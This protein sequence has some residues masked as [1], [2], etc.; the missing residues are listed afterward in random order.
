MIQI[1]YFYLFIVGVL[2]IL[3]ISDLVVGVGNDAV[4]FLNG[5]IGSKAAKFKV[6]LWV[7]T[8]G[9]IVGS[10]FS[11]GMM[12]I[13]RNGVFYPEKFVFAEV[14]IIF[15]A[16]MFADVL[17]LDVFN[18]LGLPTSTTVSI[19]F[20]LIGAALAVAVFKKLSSDG[21]LSGVAEYINT[22]N[23]LG[24][25]S[26]ILLSV[27]ISF[28]FGALIQYIARILFTFNIEKNYKRFAAIWGG[29][30]IS[31]ITYFLL[32]KGLKGASFISPETYSLIKHNTLLIM[33]VSL[34]AWTAILQLL[35]VLFKVNSLKIVVLFGTFA[36]AMSFAG[37]DLVNFIGVPLAG[38]ESF[39][40][41]LAN[42]GINPQSMEMGYLNN[43]IKT[44]TFFLLSAGVIMALTLWFSKK[45]RT[46]TRTEVNL[47]RQTEGSERFQSSALSRSIV[48]AFISMGKFLDLIVP[49]R[50]QKW[51]DK[52]FKQEK[53]KSNI[54]DKDKPSFDL[55]RGSVNLVVSSALIALGTS[56]KLP[57]STTYVTF[58]V[59]MGSSFSDQAWGRE[60]AV[61]RVSGVLTVIG[62]WFITAFVAFTLSFI[63]ATALYFGGFIALIIVIAFVFFI[64]YRSHTAHRQSEK[65]QKEVEEKVEISSI[66]KIKAW[67]A[68]IAAYMSASEDFIED[69]IKFLIQEKRGKM[70][71]VIN[72]NKKLNKELKELKS[73]SPYIIKRL[74]DENFDNG[75][76]YVQSIDQVKEISDCYSRLMQNIW[77]YID[78][79]HP[80]I[81]LDQATDL[82]SLS[83]EVG[84][85][86]KECGK[87][88]AKKDFSTLHELEQTCETLEERIDK[89]SV[90]NLKLIKKDEIGTRSSVLV[91]H[92][93]HETK[94]IITLN[95]KVIKCMKKFD[96]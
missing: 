57:L 93:L 54:K 71:K 21:G 4:N 94:N 43:A 55:V 14:M 50:M 47:S 82:L 24:F 83:K 87:A 46:V 41:F 91:T 75:F 59:A 28:T 11:S 90:K 31:I 25:M 66:E 13:A 17:L 2:F 1:E 16:V 48:R 34:I 19:L 64:A 12:E 18:T 8:A 23:I 39:K 51:L 3:A 81:H 56:L 76:M 73:A 88:I 60:S 27:V 63:I 10:V 67:N 86:T 6:I 72:E 30:S 52:R 38:Y 29:L 69:P 32:I 53:V 95:L 35:S 65:K 40:V 89:L 7:A 77:K 92:I 9:V 5:A 42:S 22:A 62:G 78:N 79:H 68:K 61:Y 45:A 80:A 85:Y 44:P 15:L 20:D 96:K 37:N 33:A 49:K 26:A 58:M 74:E 70:Q 36:L 84:I